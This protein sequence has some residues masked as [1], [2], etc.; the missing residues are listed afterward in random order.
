MQD[1]YTG[2]IGDFGK[3]GL[4]RALAAPCDGAPLRLGVVWYRTLDD[5][6][7]GD[8]AFVQY[9]L[10]GSEAEFRRCDPA[11]YDG[12]RELVMSGRR[13]V[14]AVRVREILPPST[15]YYE[16]LLSYV[17]APKGRRLA[18]RA[19]WIE[20]ATVATAPCDLV[21]LDPD[22]G[23]RSRPLTGSEAELK[24][25]HC[26][27]L[28]PYLARGQS[29]VIYHHLGRGESHRAQLV[30]WRRTLQEALALPEAPIALRFARRS[31]RAFFVL[32]APAHRDAI[33][34][35]L[36]HFSAGPWQAIFPP[37]DALGL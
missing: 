11:L 20:Q 9:L 37:R 1:G 33:H 30:T 17:G 4:L 6:Q 2:D 12:L 23:L 29:L 15:I 8:G 36:S 16:S 18:V 3:Y 26:D 21:F 5:P 13:S 25:A 14:A 31:P 35:A 10:P 19:Q 28:R 32:P 27:E 7:R 22:N 34:R 24:A